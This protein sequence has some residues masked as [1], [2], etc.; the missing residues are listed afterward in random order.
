M[1]K[2]SSH[3]LLIRNVPHEVFIMLEQ[4]ARKHHRSKNQEALNALLLGLTSAPVSVPRPKQ[5]KWKTPLT[6]KFVQDAIDEGRQ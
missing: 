3:S 1:S 2:N 6:Q 5:L 4:A